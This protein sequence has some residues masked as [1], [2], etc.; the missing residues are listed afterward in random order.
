MIGADEIRARRFYAQFDDVS[1]EDSYDVRRNDN[2]TV[3]LPAEGHGKRVVLK[4]VLE[5]YA[6]TYMAVVRS[7]ESLRDYG[8]MESDFIKTCVKEITTQIE[9]ANCKYGMYSYLPR[10]IVLNANVNGNINI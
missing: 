10:F 8:L 5:P 1:S 6:H 9:N 2:I 3:T 4:S 7:L